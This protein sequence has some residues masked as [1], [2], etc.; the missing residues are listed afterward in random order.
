MKHGS[1]Q[2]TEMSPQSFFNEKLIPFPFFSIAILSESA[3]ETSIK[4]KSTASVLGMYWHV[5][6][7]EKIRNSLVWLK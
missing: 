1:L 2:K 3:K 7:I 4:F 5:R 6:K